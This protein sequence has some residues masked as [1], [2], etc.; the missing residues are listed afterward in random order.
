VS[1]QQRGLQGIGVQLV[2]A[3]G[4]ATV[5]HDKNLVATL[6]LDEVV[7]LDDK[8]GLGICHHDSV[9]AS[10]DGRFAILLVEDGG[11]PSGP[12][13]HQEAG[14]LK[15]IAIRE[16]CEDFPRSVEGVLV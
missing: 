12:S 9:T 3:N 7:S 13:M 11:L 2:Y 10:D 4:G 15:T 14:R 8:A 16:S 5:P 1:G 6:G